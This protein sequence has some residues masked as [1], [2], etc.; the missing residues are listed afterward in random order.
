MN[1]GFIYLVSINNKV[2]I[3]ASANFKPTNTHINST[4]PRKIKLLEEYNIPSP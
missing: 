3:I 2:N 1:G 4:K